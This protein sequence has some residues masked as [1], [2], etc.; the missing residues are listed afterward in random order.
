MGLAFGIFL[1]GAF[2][3]PG[4]LDPSFD[5]NGIVKTDFGSGFYSTAGQPEGTILVGGQSQDYIAALALQPDG[6][7]VAAGRS[8]RSRILLTPT[9]PITLE[10][11]DANYTLAR[12]LPNG[13]LDPQFGSGGKVITD[14]GTK[15]EDLLSRVFVL[16]DGKI[17]AVGACSDKIGLARYLPNGALDSSFGAGGKVFI[18]LGRYR[19][20]PD[21]PALL[22]PDGKVL[23][24]TAT[25][26]NPV[27]LYN[28]TL[29]PPTATVFRLNTDGTLDEAFGAQGRVELYDAS[30][31]SLTGINDMVLLPNGDIV[32]V[33]VRPSGAT[34]LVRILPSGAFDF[35][36]GQNG[37]CALD[38]P[39]PTAM[40]LQADGKFLILRPSEI[41]NGYYGPEVLNF[42]VTRVSADGVIDPTFGNAGSV[43]TDFDLRCDYARA[44]AIEG[45]G[46]FIVAGDAYF[47]GKGNAI[48]IARYHPDGTLDETF[49]TGGKVVSQLTQAPLYPDPNIP[50][51]P[52]EGSDQAF[53]LLCQSDGK[54]VVGGTSQSLYTATGND[55][56]LARYLIDNSLS[57][58]PY[59]PEVD[60]ELQASDTVPVTSSTLLTSA[61]ARSKP[62]P[63]KPKAQTRIIDAT[64]RNFGTRF[65]LFTL[66]GT[67][68]NSQMKVAYHQGSTD[69]TTAVATGTY[70]T[71]LMS[72]E[73]FL[74]L[75]ITVK[76]TRKTRRHFKRWLVVSAT[77]RGNGTSTG[78]ASVRIQLKPIRL[79]HR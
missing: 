3:E 71:P 20:N 68:G 40:A 54:I 56:L 29:V 78:A 10:W 55:F 7:I 48:A 24:A 14:M 47:Y 19:A 9:E 5:Y 11:D 65:D 60:A 36:F 44:I 62:Q 21:F 39:A 38:I 35:T 22:Q 16:P 58:L 79:H 23:V 67:K 42:E 52:D 61:K 2:A 63:S 32:I 70:Q 13:R 43:S 53:A 25:A 34:S 6:K 73:D 12:Y 8:S 50:L 66:R 45:D 17:L 49:G 1:S 30:A 27:G 4:G 57:S 46:R 33:G 59:V 69:V 37:T 76:A 41:H 26:G 72:P 18:P 28:P 15:D 31:T 64:V 77:S 51:L 75:T 74:P